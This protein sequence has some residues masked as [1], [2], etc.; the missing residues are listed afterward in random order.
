MNTR[1]STLVVVL[2]ATG[3]AGLWLAAASRLSVPGAMGHPSEPTESHSPSG[4]DKPERA[5]HK[6]PLSGPLPPT[7][8]PKRFKKDKGAFVAYAAAA[9]VPTLLYQEPCYCPCD[10]S[11]GHRSLHDC[12]TSTHGIECRACRREAIFIYEQHKTGKTAREIRDAMER[13]EVWQIDFDQ[14]VDEHYRELAK[15]QR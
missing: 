13:G 5:Y 14:Y 12:F 4:S 7:I 11:E 10:K 3:A 15:P 8:N 1:T 2:F 6:G 9:R